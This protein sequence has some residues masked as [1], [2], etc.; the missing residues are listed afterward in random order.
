MKE[1][2]LEK[3]TWLGIALLGTLVDFEPSSNVES[4]HGCLTGLAGLVLI[5]VTPRISDS[6][7]AS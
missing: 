3:T 5:Y 2:F 7:D 6:Q 1:K 4:L